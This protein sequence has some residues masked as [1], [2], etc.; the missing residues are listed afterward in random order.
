MTPLFLRKCA[1]RS[2]F[3]PI[4][5]PNVRPGR[6]IPYCRMVNDDLLDGT[7]EDAVAALRD[8]AVSALE[9]TD[10][11]LA[12]IDR[13]EAELNA[14][15]TV[16]ADDARRRARD[17]DARPER[18][19]L[20]G[21]PIALK[22]LFDVAGVATTA[23]SKL[24]AMNV[25]PADSA[26]AASLFAAGAVNVGKTNLHEWAFGVT[27]NNPHFGP[28]RNPWAPDRIP[29]GSSGGNG[30]ALVAGEV[31][32]TIGSDTGG[33]IRIPASLCGIVGLKATYGRVSLRGAI[34]LGWSLDHAGPMTRTVR[35]A[36]LL[37]NVI[38]GYDAADPVSV[39]VPVQDHLGEIEAG[40]RG[41]R[42]GYVT[43][44]FI[45]R[46]APEDRPAAGVTAARRAAARPL[47]RAGAPSGE[48]ESPRTG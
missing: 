30:A 13:R 3:Q 2:S 14:F 31:F 17:I 29:G 37:L 16:T 20:A 6:R 35:D 26:V 10:A 41:L 43:G 47:A 24:F 4:T 8:R 39:D 32:G 34:P 28:T 33:S 5:A 7:L 22:D 1:I 44:R 25:P 48:G 18:P 23:G 46:L 27:T 11:T 45:T 19:T 40:V 15:I 42:I 21:V 38:A 12:R 9:L 36:A